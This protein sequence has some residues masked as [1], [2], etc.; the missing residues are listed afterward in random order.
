MSKLV[1]SVSSQKHIYIYI[2]IYKTAILLE[3]E[4]PNIHLKQWL[5]PAKT[6]QHHNPEDPDCHLPADHNQYNYTVDLYE[7]ETLLSL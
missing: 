2:K 7:C 1:V 3:S 6:T 5:P 4:I